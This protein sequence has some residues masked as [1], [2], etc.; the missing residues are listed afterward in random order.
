MLSITGAYA[1]THLWSQGFGHSSWNEGFDV[2]ADGS[3]N[4]YTTGAFRDTIVFGNDTLTSAGNADVFLAKFDPAGNHVWSARFGTYSLDQGLGV[5]CDAWGNV[6][7]AGEFASTISLGGYTLTS[8][9]ESDI[10]LAKFDGDGDHVWSRGFGG[11]THWDEPRNIAVDNAGNVLLTG[12]FGVTI[13]FGGGP[14]T[15]I[16]GQDIFIAKFDADG[17]HIWSYGYSH[18]SGQW[19]GGIAA[20]SQGNVL[21]TAVYRDTIDVGGGPL[22]HSG[23]L[24]SV[25]A[26]FDPLGNHVWSQSFNIIAI[27]A[28][29][30]HDVAVDGSNNVHVTGGF[31]GFVDFGGGTLTA[32]IEDTFVAKYDTNGDHVWSRNFTPSTDDDRAEGI[33]VDASGNVFLAGNFE[34]SVD[35]GGGPLTSAGRRDGYIAMLDSNGQHVWSLRF[36][37]ETRDWAN[38]V[39]VDPWGNAIVIGLFE[40]T[41]DLGGGPI[42]AGGITDFFLAKYARE[43]GTSTQPV[44]VPAEPVLHQNRPN[45]FNP[46]T[47]IS[48]DLARTQHVKL[49][50]Y[51]AQGTLVRVL[52]DEEK[53]A[54]QNFITW[55]GRD[56]RGVAVASGV[57]FYRLTS[58]EAQLTQKMTLLK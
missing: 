15:G 17:N 12:N 3:G 52:V 19:G 22:T 18:P 36:G 37:Q 41:I 33:A 24:G 13:D 4:I 25:L 26:K 38:R 39:V 8:V 50:I 14:L 56:H 45:P 51:D 54:G 44:P 47:S 43:L 34:G 31:G 6:I 58:G 21:W 7:L 27:G 23:G 1:Q 55:D 48:F 57:Y 30:S 40:G 9:G 53:P 46:E 32:I 5:T 29:R 11:P 42:T 16:N 2:A 10:F 49:A 35:L 28:V 20:D